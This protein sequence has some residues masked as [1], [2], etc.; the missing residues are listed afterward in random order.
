[1]IF[2]SFRGI[3]FYFVFVY[4]VYFSFLLVLVLVICV[5]REVVRDRDGFKGYY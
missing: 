1:M 5:F 2:G 4:R 3:Y